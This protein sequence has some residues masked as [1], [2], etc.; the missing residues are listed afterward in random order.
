VKRRTFIAGLGSRRGGSAAAWHL[1]STIRVPFTL[2]TFVH[3]FSLARDRH[4]RHTAM[5]EGATA[6]TAVHWTTPWPLSLQW[7]DKRQEAQFG[8][9]DLTGAYR[10]V[11]IGSN[12]VKAA[13]HDHIAPVGR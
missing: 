12:S 3:G 8:G 5:Y 11:T 4:A 9:H 13:H 2:E 10:W 1:L 7:R 6:R